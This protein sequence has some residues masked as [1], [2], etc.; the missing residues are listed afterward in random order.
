MDEPPPPE[1]GE[2]PVSDEQNVAETETL[3]LQ[4]GT[5]EAIAGGAGLDGN[6]SE[7]PG[8]PPKPA[9]LSEE[10]AQS[11]QQSLEQAQAALLPDYPPDAPLPLDPNFQIQLPNFEGPLDLLLYLIKK[12][13]LDILDLPIAFVTEKYVEYIQLFEEL[14]LDIASEY[15]VMAATLAHIKSKSLLPKPPVDQDDE[16]AEEEV[17]PRAEL[18]R[19]L[20]EYQKYKRAAQQLGSRGIAG[21]DVFPRGIPAPKAEG[22]A[23]L[24]EFNVFKL[25]DAFQKLV[26]RRQGQLSMEIDAERITIQERIG[27]LAD[28]LRLSERVA[29]DSLFDE[30]LTRYDIVVTFMALLEMAKMR[31]IKIYQSD[32]L[33]PLYL[34]QRLQAVSPD[35]EEAFGRG[36][37]FAVESE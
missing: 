36:S 7:T 32:P 20:L 35:D 10:D 24:A 14:N 4:E 31:M 28:R 29:F 30:F 5:P 33:E 1:G 37:A 18:I 26:K 22:P 2:T 12:H 25:I 17:D 27:Q 6:S 21:R 15:L 9:Q 3:E 11:V 13:E 34:E 23:P 19:R 8:D 16:Y